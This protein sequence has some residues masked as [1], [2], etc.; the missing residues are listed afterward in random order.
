LTRAETVAGHI[1]PKRHTLL[2]LAAVFIAVWFGNLDYRRL[3]RPDEGRYAEIAREMATTGDWVT[4]RLNGIKYFEKPPLQYWATA[5]AY[6][7]FGVHEWTARLWAALTG[8]FGVLLV[9]CAGRTLFGPVAG[10]DSALVLAG[11]AGYVGVGHMNTLDMGVA[12]FLT[13]TLVAFLLAQRAG[14]E[15]TE[16][17]N[18]ML[19][20][21]ASAA[22]AVLSK[23]LI[24]VVLPLGTLA[25]YVMLQRD[26]TI[27]R[28]LEW[29]AGIAI[30]FMIAA[31]WFVLV[32][33]AN[34][35][36]AAFF[37][38]HEHFTRFLT[39]VHRRVEPWWYFFPI[40][41]A[42]MLPWLT[43]LPQALA[44]AWRAPAPAGAFH[45]KRFLLVWTA[46]TF[47]FF[48]L[49]SS[50]LPGY[51]LP[52]VPALALLVGSW[53]SETEPRRLLWHAIPVLLAGA[54]L[55][56]LASQAALLSSST[57]PRH[58]FEAYVPWIAAGGII[59]AVGAGFAI[60]WCL[61]ERAV[62][63]LIAMACGGLIST[64]VVTSGHDT[65]SPWYSGYHIARDLKPHLADNVPFYSVRTYDQTLCF[66]IQR[67]VTLVAFQDEMAYGLEREPHLWLRDLPSFERIW[68][69]QRRA[70]AIMGP[71]THAELERSGLP[72]Q[73]IARDLRRIVVRKPDA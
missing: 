59:L 50:K 57:L 21:W 42:A 25:I 18:W 13:A 40:L 49:S 51:I 26:F 16:R 43:M 47:A 31:P 72:M 23:G 33:L 10:L 29:R 41:A 65:L 4:P 11:S 19:A 52:L 62:A 28:H 63:A 5:A 54:G 64:Q 56:A 45:P 36:F 58:L 35:E 53:L 12:F 60:Y 71:D 7:L 1:Y 6:R 30:C 20:A 34:P 27:L 68:H 61:R 9:Y 66:Y 69:D 2:L 15:P 8:M 73:V 14:A 70:L 38:V 3:I 32:Q 48:S 39:Q 37:F 22:L 24:G 55:A 17:R 44:G 46:F 67:T